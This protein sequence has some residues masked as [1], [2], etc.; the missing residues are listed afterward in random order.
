MHNVYTFHLVWSFVFRFFRTPLCGST[1]PFWTFPH[2]LNYWVQFQERFGA[3]WTMLKPYSR[4]KAVNHKLLFCC[5][6]VPP[7]KYWIEA[8]VTFAKIDRKSVVMHVENDSAQSR[9]YVLSVEPIFTHTALDHEAI[10]IV[11]LPTNAV[12]SL[13]RHCWFT[14]QASL[15]SFPCVCDSS[16]ET[17]PL[18]FIE[19]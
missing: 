11:R 13:L 5:S 1:E 17:D 16:I 12:N 9:G 6:N 8:H 4:T 14:A 10:S 15:H 2:N 19:F 7:W 3:K 18:T